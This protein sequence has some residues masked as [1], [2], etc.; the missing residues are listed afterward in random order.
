LN[1][2][3]AVLEEPA[4]LAEIA[5]R[6]VSKR[7]GEGQPA[8]HALNLA[9]GNGEFV[10]LVGPSGCGK[11][12]ALRMVAGLEDISGGELLIGGRVAND[13]APRE[14]NIAMVFQSYA[15]YPHLTVAENIGF[16]LRVRGTS[17]AGIAKKVET[18][19]QILE[20][21]EF[22]HRKPS[23]L[24]G[25]QRQR[26]A[27]GRAIV[28][29]P[30]AF[31]MDEPLS[32]LDARLRGQMRTEIARIQ[33][34]TGVTTIYVTHD[35]VE[36][37][38]MGDKVAVMN[39][40]VLQQ[41]AAP[42]TLYD[43]PANIFVASFIGSPPMNMIEGRVVAGDGGPALMLGATRIPLPRALLDKKPALAGHV[44][45]TVV[46]GVRPEGF[47]ASGSGAAI[48]GTVAVAEDLGSA[49]LVHLDIDAPRPHLN[50]DGIGL[51]QDEEALAGKRD[52]AR[53]RLNLHGRTRIKAGD[54]LPVSID[55]DH[56]HLFD[57][58][59]GAAIAR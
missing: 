26:V 48:P 38:T 45:K 56:L 10:V 50:L 39:R 15:L 6:N 4:V 32:N 43:E 2:R 24:S 3:I 23:Q 59:T 46:A 13:L 28:R 49:I 44:G 1:G 40:G 16:G 52:Q 34:M 55:L 47:A 5:F 8:V 22:L 12:T 33:R 31:L 19:A 25:G 54:A 21:G 9:I 7:Y 58:A 35:Q 20:L 57:P 36:A 51:S 30:Q 42:R 37:M 11:S 27:M 41:F 14:R 53:I 17:A 29:E 18:A